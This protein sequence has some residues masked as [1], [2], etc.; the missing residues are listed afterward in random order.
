MKLF[1][2]QDPQTPYPGRRAAR[3][4]GATSRG[5]LIRAAAG[6][7]PGRLPALRRRS[8]RRR[9]PLAIRAALAHLA[10]AGA[11]AG[12][13]AIGRYV[14]VATHEGMFGDR[15]F[16]YLRVVPPGAAVTPIGDGRDR[17]APAVAEHAA[18]RWRVALLAALFTVLLL[19]SLRRRRAGEKL[20]WAG[21]FALFAVA[22]GARGDRPGL[23]LERRAVPRLLPV[24]AAC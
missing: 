8:R 16:I 15:D 6:R 19:R 4:R 17:A 7:P 13:C 23:G 9:I 2:W 14:L 11:D 18:C 1:A 20:L 21:G 24:R 22:T 12:R 3:P 5:L 10:G